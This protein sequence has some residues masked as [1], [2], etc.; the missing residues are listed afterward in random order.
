[1]LLSLEIRSKQLLIVIV[2]NDQV[3]RQDIDNT[4]IRR[5]LLR[6]PDN[7][8]EGIP[9]Y[10]IIGPNMPVLITPNITT[11]LHISNG[12]IARLVKVV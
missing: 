1:M 6:I 5:F 12:S 2:A 11:E 8:T 9:G 3:R 4:E 7:K 10:L